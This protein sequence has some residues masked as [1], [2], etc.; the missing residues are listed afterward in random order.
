M[1]YGVGFPYATYLLLRVRADRAPDARRLL[2]RWTDR[3]TFGRR[4]PSAELDAQEPPHLNLAFTF[5]GLRVLGVPQACLAQFPD[6]FREGAAARSE[7]LGTT[8]TAYVSTGSSDGRR[9]M[10]S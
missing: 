5:P 10:S 7:R 8:A 1:A 4:E 3:V 6:E 2:G 9:A